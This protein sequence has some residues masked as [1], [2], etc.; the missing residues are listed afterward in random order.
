L[1]LSFIAAP[2]LADADGDVAQRQQI[3]REMQTALDSLDAAGK[4]GDIDKSRDGMK[5]DAQQLAR[6]AAQPWQMF[7]RETT[8]ARRPSHAGPQIWSDPAGFRSGGSKLIETTQTLVASI[9]KGSADDIKKNVAA[10]STA[11]ETCHQ[12]YKQ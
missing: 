4:S 5:T 11:C 2:A 12:T 1:L 3:F 7:G 10:V 6:L 9:P 8:I